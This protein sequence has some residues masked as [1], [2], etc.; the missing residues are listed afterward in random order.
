VA[1]VTLA[2]VTSFPLESAIFT[3]WLAVL[4]LATILSNALTTSGA[5]P[6]VIFIPTNPV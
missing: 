4:P 6:T 1:I 3:V 2:P 5:F